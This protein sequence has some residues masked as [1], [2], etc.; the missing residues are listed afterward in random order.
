MFQNLRNYLDYVEDTVESTR[1][2][3]NKL[4]GARRR[5]ANAIEKAEAEIKLMRNETKYVASIKPQIQKDTLKLSKDILFNQARSA[6]DKNKEFDDEIYRVPLFETIENNDTYLVRMYGSGF[7]SK[8]SVDINLN[9]TAGVLNLWGAAVKAARA[10]LS[11]K[12]PRKG[13]K[14]YERSAQSASKAWA[15]HYS[16]KDDKYYTMIETRLQLSA[17]PAPFWSI[18]NFGTVPLSSDRGGFPTPTNKNTDFVG[19][20]EREI[21]LATRGLFDTAKEEFNRTFEQLN[22]FLEEEYARRERL[23][24]IVNQVHLDRAV[25]RSLERKMNFDINEIDKNKLEKAVDRVRK[26]LLTQGR[27]S[28]GSGRRKTLSVNVIKEFLINYG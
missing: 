24:D 13:S 27:V 3:L 23:N 7:N 22:A 14:V 10:R 25:V 19:K 9:R 20:A 4:N 28:I 18:L 15:R 21:Q 16:N 26:G 2:F 5:Q 11:V 12:V 6:L 8:V 17:K 1:E